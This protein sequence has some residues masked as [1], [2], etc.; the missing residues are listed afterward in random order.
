MIAAVVLAGLLRVNDRS[1][2]WIHMYIH[3]LVHATQWLEFSKSYPLKVRA[4]LPWIHSPFGGHLAFGAWTSPPQRW[5]AS[6]GHMKWLDGCLF[7]MDLSFDARAQLV[8][9]QSSDKH[10]GIKCFKN[11]D[12]K[13]S[14]WLTQVSKLWAVVLKTLLWEWGKKVPAIFGLALLPCWHQLPARKRL[15]SGNFR[16]Q[17]HSVALSLSS[18]TTTTTHW[19]MHCCA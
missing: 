10:S 3:V 19:L 15:S 16:L 1:I 5:C 6:L 17:R 2:E 7:S 18:I 12:V 8:H 9:S 4:F 11:S 13:P 14:R